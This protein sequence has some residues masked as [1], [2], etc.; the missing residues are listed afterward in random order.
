MLGWL[1]LDGL[2]KTINPN[3]TQ[4]KAQNKVR[5]VIRIML[6]LQIFRNLFFFF[7]FS[8]KFEILIPHA[9]N[10]KK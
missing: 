10:P 7:F 8:I 9:L 6:F 2:K 3:S 5:W 4:P 1:E